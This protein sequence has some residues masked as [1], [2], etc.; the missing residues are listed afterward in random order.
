MKPPT[1]PKEVFKQFSGN[2]AINIPKPNAIVRMSGE[3]G[4]WTESHTRGIICNPV[5]VGIGPFPPT[6]SEE[7]W[8]KGA[9]TQIANEGPEQFLVNLLH[10]LR[11]TFRTEEQK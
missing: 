10:V 5:F 6:V 1:D 4:E 9:M 11:G 3:T 7:E 8:I 2:S